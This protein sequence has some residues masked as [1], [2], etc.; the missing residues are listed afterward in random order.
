MAPRCLDGRLK[1]LLGSGGVDEGL[2][3]CSKIADVFGRRGVR[4][5]LVQPFLSVDGSLLELLTGTGHWH[6]L[7]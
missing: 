4:V 6:H 7:S 2:G 3:Y 1:V 5:D